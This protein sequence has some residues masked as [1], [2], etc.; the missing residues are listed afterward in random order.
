MVKSFIALFLIIFSVVLYAVITDT[1]INSQL[2]RYKLS[3]SVVLIK[4]DSPNEDKLTGTTSEIFWSGTGFSILNDG[5]YSY[6]ITNKHVCYPMNTA[7]Y[8]LIDISGANH[9]ALYVKKD[10]LSDLCMLKT[11]SYV[12]P[13]KVADGNALFGEKILIIG[14]P[15]GVFP[16]ITGGYIGAYQDV[17]SEDFK[18]ETVMNETFKFRSQLVSATI[19]PGNSGSPVFNEDGEVIG[20]V[21]GNN[22]EAGSIGFIVP[23]DLVKIFIKK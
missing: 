6:I 15:K 2:G 4:V 10:E 7:K 14:A 16:M 12:P 9:R 3:K 5:K 23:I 11:L 18:Q 17:S 13:V 20:V 21:F 19:Y 22:L 8:T 1:N